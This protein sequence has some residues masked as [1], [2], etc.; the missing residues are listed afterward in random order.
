MV[1][2]LIAEQL[3]AGLDL[4]ESIHLG[5]LARHSGFC[6]DL[7]FRI[8]SL[9]EYH[10]RFVPLAGLG[11]LHRAA[12]KVRRLFA[13]LAVGQLN[14]LPSLGICSDLDSIL[15]HPAPSGTTPRQAGPTRPGR[16]SPLSFLYFVPPQPECADK[17]Q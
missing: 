8:L 7:G 4:L 15:R 2:G 11:P 1:V 13:V 10:F 9:I 5:L 12:I 14:C 3:D 16:Q 6:T 17:Q